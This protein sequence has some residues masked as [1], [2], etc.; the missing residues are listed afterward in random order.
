MDI[1]T[2]PTRNS[3]IARSIANVIFGSLILL[4]PGITLAVLAVAFAINILIVGL[5]MLFEPA[6][7]STNK[8]ALLTVISG[9]LAIGAGV[10]VLSRPLAGVVILSIIIAA[11]ALL[12][13]LMD[14]FIGFKLS[15][16]KLQ[17]SWIYILI[18]I[19]SLMFAVYLAFNPLE[20][21][22]ALVGVVGIYSLLIGFI[23]GFQ[24]FKIKPEK[25][26][27]AKTTTPKTSGPI[28]KPAKTIVRKTSK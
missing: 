1:V 5:F 7:D 25:A 14:L 10:Y 4:F 19:L 13:G 2:T 9:L 28:K 11:W 6:F 16:N 24:A 3:L 12:Y 22:L 15:E 8:H 21:S 17:G 18:G 26:I 23:F 20:G 27:K